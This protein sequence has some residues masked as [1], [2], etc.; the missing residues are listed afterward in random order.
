LL[1][2][3]AFS[4]TKKTRISLADQSRSKRNEAR[5]PSDAIFLNKLSTDET[6]LHKSTMQHTNADSSVPR[7]LN[8]GGNSGVMFGE[9]FQSYLSP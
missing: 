2:K 1:G 9:Q 7:L 4:T 8:A 5:N 6:S 3:D